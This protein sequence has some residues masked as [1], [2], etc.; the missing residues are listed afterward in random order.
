MGSACAEAL[1]CE[2]IRPEGRLVMELRRAGTRS[3]QI[4]C[5][6]VVAVGPFCLVSFHLLPIPVY[7]Q[8]GEVRPSLAYK[9]GKILAKRSL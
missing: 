3:C 9:M 8:R 7:L 2:G 6:G 1:R 4:A 5:H